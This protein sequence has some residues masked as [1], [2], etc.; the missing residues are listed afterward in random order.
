MPTGIWTEHTSEAPETKG[1]KYY[2]NSLLQKT[3]WE[4][5]A[6]AHVA[7]PTASPLASASQSSNQFSAQRQSSEWQAT[8]DSASGRVYYFNMRTNE[9]SWENPEEKNQSGPV[10][11]GAK[12]IEEMKKKLQRQQPA[13]VQKRKAESRLEHN[14]KSVKRRGGSSSAYEQMVAEFR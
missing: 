9:T 11:V 13:A 4:R 14:S 6:G 2:F 8:V 12:H 1:R 7:R 5:P 10:D 3:Q